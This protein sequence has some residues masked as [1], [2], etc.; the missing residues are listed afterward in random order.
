M[1]VWKPFSRKSER[2]KWLVG[3]HWDL[4]LMLFLWLCG[5]SF[6]LR[7]ISLGDLSGN[8][9]KKPM[10]VVTKNNQ[11]LG[12]RHRP[13]GLDPAPSPKSNVV[14]LHLRSRTAPRDAR[15]TT[16][17]AGSARTRRRRRARSTIAT[18]RSQT[19]PSVGCAPASSPTRFPHSI[20][21]LSHARLST[22]ADLDAGL[23]A[24]HAR[25]RPTLLRRGVQRRV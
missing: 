16:S 23:C 17:S 12:V 21:L 2:V 18:L 15:P 19:S 20:L 25:A 9:I 7:Q 3:I 1:K 14:P 6:F 13:R 4:L 8:G 5:S 11:N 22:P 10:W 24:V